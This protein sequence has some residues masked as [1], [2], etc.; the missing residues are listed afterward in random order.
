MVVLRR[1]FGINGSALS[2]VAEFL[3][4][5]RQVVC[6]GKS[7]SDYMALQFGVPQGSVLGPCVSVQYTE[8]VDDIFQRQGG[9]RH[10]FADD[11]QGHCS[12]RLDDIPEIVSA[13][14][15]YY[16]HPRLVRCQTFTAQC[17]QDRP[18]VV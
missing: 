9:H 12:R 16:R 13:Q 15:L 4:N 2:W 7:E 8:D 6:A 3:S 18:T 10:L 11:M 14:K 1:Q 17:R 5:R